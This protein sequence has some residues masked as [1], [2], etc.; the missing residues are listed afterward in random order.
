MQSTTVSTFVR[1]IKYGD[2]YFSLFNKDHNK[3]YLTLS[4]GS[5]QLESRDC[6][7][8]CTLVF[9]SDYFSST[10][11]NVVH[12]KYV[13]DGYSKLFEKDNAIENGYCLNNPDS[14]TEHIFALEMKSGDI[15]K[16]I[17]NNPIF[18][19]YP[20][21]VT[22]LNMYLSYVNYY[23]LI[24]EKLPNPVIPDRLPQNLYSTQFHI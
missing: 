2:C 16:Q 9:G 7:K 23:R 12:S 14:Q 3:N 18:L 20:S 4:P 1:L 22:F 10:I 6:D 11:S 15:S 8:L 24:G 19:S 17:A 13:E 21:N 5:S